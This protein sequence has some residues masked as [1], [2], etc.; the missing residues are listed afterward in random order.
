MIKIHQVERDIK[1]IC[2]ENYLFE[3]LQPAAEEQI[4]KYLEKIKKDF[5]HIQFEVLTNSVKLLLYTSEDD[6]Y[7]LSFKM[8]LKQ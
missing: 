5:H 6:G 8:N 4:V 1:K 7:D 2:L 3:K